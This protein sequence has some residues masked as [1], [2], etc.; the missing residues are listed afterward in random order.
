MP[1]ITAGAGFAVAAAAPDASMAAT[2]PLASILPACAGAAATPAAAAD[3]NTPATAGPINA[4]M[5]PASAAAPCSSTL[6]VSLGTCPSGTM[7]SMVPATDIAAADAIACA[8]PGAAVGILGSHAGVASARACS[9][10]SRPGTFGSR[11]EG[12][13]SLPWSTP[14]SR[15]ALRCLAACSCRSKCPGAAGSCAAPAGVL[16][17]A[18]GVG[19][20]EPRAWAVMLW[21][22]LQWAGRRRPA[23]R[24]RKGYGR[25]GPPVMPLIAAA[26]TACVRRSRPAR[27]DPRP[28][29]PARDAGQRRCPARFRARAP[30][31]SVAHLFQLPVLAADLGGLLHDRLIDP[32]DEFLTVEQRRHAQGAVA[33]RRIFLPVAAAAR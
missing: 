31:A 2:L 4:S 18:G 9:V 1:A 33:G 12:S 28:G 11:V 25:R 10:D 17:D 13:C 14:E 6:A 15:D 24:A 5:A 3:R 20:V 23:A 27:G 26:G 29:A 16:R 21:A 22:L 19:G 30:A 32:L 8:L 7:L